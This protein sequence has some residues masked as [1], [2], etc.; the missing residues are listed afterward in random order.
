MRKGFLLVDKLSTADLPA[1]QLPAGVEGQ[2][3]VDGLVAALTAD[4]GFAAVVSSPSAHAFLI[5]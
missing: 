3:D 4:Q 1:D 2:I 5:I